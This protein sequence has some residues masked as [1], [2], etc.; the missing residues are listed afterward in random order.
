MRRL[1]RV[2]EQLSGVDGEPALDLLILGGRVIDPANNL[3]GIYDL[4]VRD[5]VIVAVETSPGVLGCTPAA[6]TF[7]ARGLIVTP[8]LVDI[9]AH[10][11]QHVEPIGLDFDASC[12]Q[13]CTT[14]VVDAG[15][16]GA[17]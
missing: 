7:D 9:H 3:D 6:E 5:G 16:S 17:T 10:G 14:T 1:E 13:R 4:A 15:S 2:S 11:F 12:L 8:G